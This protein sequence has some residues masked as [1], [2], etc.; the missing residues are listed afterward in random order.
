MSVLNADGSQRMQKSIVN[1]VEQF[2]NVT[3]NVPIYQI[4]FPGGD[5]QGISN[6]E[7]RFKI[8]GPRD[9]SLLRGCRRQ[10]HHFPQ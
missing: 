2:T 8:F 4:V 10:S 9:S 1:G 3:M 6:F 5:T 7:Y